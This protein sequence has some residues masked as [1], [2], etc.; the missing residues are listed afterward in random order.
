MTYIETKNL[1]LRPVEIGDAANLAEALNDFEVARNLKN[2]PTP[3][4]PKDVLAWLGRTVHDRSR[5]NIA[6]IIE[7]EPMKLG[8]LIDFG[9]TER[10]VNIGYWLKK[11]YWGKGHMSDAL[12]AALDWYFLEDD[13][14]FI[15]SDIFEDNFASRKLQANLG[16][17]EVGTCQFNCQ[18]RGETVTAVDTVLTRQ[19]IGIFGGRA[20]LKLATDRIYL[21]PPQ[22]DDAAA[23]TAA[24]SRYE[25]AKDMAYVPHPYTLEDA[26]TWLAKQPQI[27][28]PYQQKFAIFTH[29]DQFCGMTGFTER[30]GFPRSAI[31]CIEIF[32]AK[33]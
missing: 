18:T 10:G 2:V 19:A 7:V 25:V 13:R 16:F 23:V 30:E 24:L 20:M 8:G 32:G 29:E 15:V 5:D 21:R 17:E 3:C 9:K 11:Q 27:S 4:R 14:D 12:R 33:A 22:V 6:F 31:I 28:P 26:E 1:L